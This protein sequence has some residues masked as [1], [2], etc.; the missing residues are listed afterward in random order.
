[1]IKGPSHLQK[2][3][4]WAMLLER[5]FT[6]LGTKTKSLHK[7]ELRKYLNSWRIIAKSRGG[8]GEMR[9]TMRLQYTWSHLEKVYN[10]TCDE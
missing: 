5:K 6:C 9:K 3:A 4:Q 7:N 10:W 2:I 1:M 8:G